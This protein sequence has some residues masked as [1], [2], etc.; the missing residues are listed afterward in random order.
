MTRAIN[1]SASAG[2]IL[3]S[4]STRRRLCTVRAASSRGREL[5]RANGPR[6]GRW[7]AHGIRRIQMPPPELVDGPIARPFD[8]PAEALKDWRA[9]FHLENSCLDDARR[10]R[11]VVL[12]AVLFGNLDQNKSLLCQRLGVEIDLLR[13]MAGIDG[14]EL[15]KIRTQLVRESLPEQVERF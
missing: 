8:D 6:I 7:P 2:G 5:S 14:A 15:V 13:K 3:P 4:R 11:G 12:P 1:P 10:R 9:Q